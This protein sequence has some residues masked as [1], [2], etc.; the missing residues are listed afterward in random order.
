MKILKVNFLVSKFDQEIFLFHLFSM[1]ID[2][3][4]NY[5]NHVESNQMKE[6]KKRLISIIIKRDENKNKKS[7]E[8]IDRHLK[9]LKHINA[10]I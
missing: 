9:Y 7:L 8:N 10:K 5:V 3:L 4:I 6:A 1:K 2:C